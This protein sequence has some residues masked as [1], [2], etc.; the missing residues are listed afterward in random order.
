M[1][2]R[3]KEFLAS[4]GA[5]YQVVSHPDAITAQEQAAVSHTPG[6]SW[7]KVVIVNPWRHV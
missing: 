6:Q 7:A 3:L 2:L 1:N 4:S 5:R